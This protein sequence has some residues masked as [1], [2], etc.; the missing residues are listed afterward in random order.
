MQSNLMLHANFVTNPFIAVKGTYLGLFSDAN[1]PGHE[2]SGAFRGTVTDRGTFTATLR[3]GG[4]SYALAGQFDLEGKATRQIRFKPPPAAATLSLDLTNGTDQ[5]TGE[6]GSPADG[7]AAGLSTAGP[8]P[9]NPAYSGRHTRATGGLAPPCRIVMV[10]RPPRRDE[11]HDDG[12]M[13]S[14]DNRHPGR[15]LEGRFG[16]LYAALRWLVRCRA[17]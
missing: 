9:T 4:R 7:D 14:R 15:Q 6:L 12:G 8:W 1:Q 10:A 17:G 5:I 11:R 13:A 3:T 2:S 16:S